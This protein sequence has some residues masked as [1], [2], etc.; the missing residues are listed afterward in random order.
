MKLRAQPVLKDLSLVE[1]PIIDDHG[2]RRTKPKDKRNIGHGDRV[3][4]L[5]LLH[6]VLLRTEDEAYEDD[7]FDEDEDKVARRRKKRVLE[8]R[9]SNRGLG[10]VHININ[11]NVRDYTNQVKLNIVTIGRK[12][13]ILSNVTV[14]FAFLQFK[15]KQMIFSLL[16]NRQFYRA[17]NG[18]DKLNIAMVVWF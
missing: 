10:V 5:V 2:G 17:Y 9:V 11:L 12:I 1:K 6:K 4:E 7:M 3:L 13:N 14:A 15:K 8:V 18:F 16:F